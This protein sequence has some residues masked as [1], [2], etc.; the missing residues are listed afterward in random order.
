MK[1][2]LITFA[3]C[4]H[5]CLLMAQ[6]H[7]HSVIENV[8]PQP[9][10]AHSMRIADGLTFVGSPLP[11]EIYGALQK[12][13]LQRHNKHTVSTIQEKLDPLCLAT[14]HINPE[15]RVK[16]QRGAVQPIMMQRGWTTFLI[17]VHNEAGITAVL[18]PESSNALPLLHKSTS[19]HRMKEENR[20][21]PGEI[22]DHFLDLSIYA[23]RPL[24]DRLSGLAVEYFLLQLYSKDA[25]QREV[26]LSFNVGQGTQDI[27]FR[28]AISVLFNIRP[29]VKV[30]LDVM[31]HD[32]KPAMASFIFNDGIDRFQ[33][34]SHV[35]YRNTIAL[36]TH[37][38]EGMDRKERA[39]Q[40]QL[41]GIYPLPARRL[42]SKDEFP[43]FFFQ[44]QIY[45]ADGEY[46]YLPPG[47]YHV[48]YGRGPEYLSSYQEVDIPDVESTRLSFKLER[49]IHMADL[50][51]YSADHHIHAAGCSHYE[52]PEEGVNPE[53]MWRQV[54]GEDLNMG[55]N[56]TWGPSWYHQKQ[57]FTGSNHELS[58]EKN[59]LRYDVEVSGFPSSHAGH[60]VL[61]NLRED[62]Y[63][64]TTLI[65]EWPSWTLPI[66]QWAKDQGGI[67]GYA[68]S[69]WGL[70]PE[71]PTL[72]LPN[73]STPKMD[74]IG[75]NEY[76]V[77]ATHQVIDFYSAGD[78]PL[79]AEMNMWYHTLNC[80]LRI[81]IS[82]ETDFP[83]ISDE[84]VGRARIYAQ[85]DQGLDF[86]DYMDALLKGRSY[87]SEGHAHLIDFKVNEIP[88][89][90]S[91]ASLSMHA[92]Q[93]VTVEVRA[94]AYLSE[95]QDRTGAIIAG[96]DAYRSPYWHI[97]RAR[98][99]ATRKVPVE[100]LVNGV[101]VQEK[102]VVAD[103]T[104]SDLSFEQ[105]I[106]RSSWL[107]IRIPASAH[108][109]PI[110][111][112]IDDRPVQI[113]ESAVW[114]RSAVDQCWKM[115]EGKIRASEKEAAQ[116]AYESAR[117]F[118]DRIID[119]E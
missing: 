68:H 59:I 91:S 63:P 78:T 103:G 85:L 29:A 117:R 3:L 101:K 10:L 13:T 33:D 55:N 14:I 99:G 28:N 50:G 34:A 30:Y 37:W 32:G 54:Q 62:D 109:N 93:S 31:D 42:A 102:M 39:H 110:Y 25:G 98:I 75:A 95:V 114:C 21:T 87:V 38:I 49:W 19:A 71:E 77:T 57:F 115:K 45:R 8:E 40:N 22:D 53:D 7:H 107:A 97:E 69:G 16:V 6:H 70:A 94:A 52:S 48:T 66:L 86:D 89:G 88:L 35:D 113:K 106:D 1:Y 15:S 72:E 105:T 51:W 2:S 64:G 74:G 90:Q 18:Q 111:V 56:L 65:E 116:A 108:T 118:Y 100:L 104:W 60:L 24:S 80:G 46:V 84:R 36:S 4:W 20:L 26:N 67:T 79:P 5:S 11:T 23:G 92:P 12:L 27:G 81:P 44:P 61:L 76:V 58:D 43:D 112:T 119:S 47:S 9:L 82:G 83:C 41:V 96:S 73:Y 17:K